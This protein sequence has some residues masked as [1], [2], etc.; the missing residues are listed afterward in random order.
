MFSKNKKKF[1]SIL[2]AIESIFSF[3]YLNFSQAQE[4]KINSSK[5]QQK[6]IY[7]SKQE[8][9]ISI[10]KIFQKK[11]RLKIISSAVI[12]ALILAIKPK[13]SKPPPAVPQNLVPPEVPIFNGL[14]NLATTCYVNSSLQMLFHIIEFRDAILKCSDKNDVCFNLKKIFEKLEKNETVK[15]NEMLSFLESIKKHNNIGSIKDFEKVGDANEFIVCLIEIIREEIPNINDLWKINCLSEYKFL[16]SEMED[17]N[18]DEKL[19][20]L[21]LNVQEEFTQC[22]ENYFKLKKPSFDLENGEKTIIN[23]QTKIESLGKYVM[24]RMQRFGFD[25]LTRKVKINDCVIKTDKE[26][27][28]DDYTINEKYGNYKV[29]GSVCCSPSGAYIHYYFVWILNGNEALIYDDE[30]VYKIDFKTAWE[31]IE[32]FSSIILLEKN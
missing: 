9:L 2:F 28:F 10:H 32:K 15:K 18:S 16:N 24:I 6:N 26:I 19:F 29:K 13:L 8:K 31:H 22:V 17:F 25:H 1:L 5:F 3:E 11:N 7:N 12:I 20:S 23:A 30:K 14:P 27:N 4:A 21:P